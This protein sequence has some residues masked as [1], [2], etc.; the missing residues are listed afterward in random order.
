MAQLEATTSQGVA[1]IENLRGQ[2]EQ[3]QR[4]QDKLKVADS[5]LDLSHQ[6]MT[7]MRKRAFMN[8]LIRYATIGI[9]LLGTNPA[10]P[11]HSARHRIHTLS[12]DRLALLAKTVP[13]A[14]GTQL[15]ND[16]DSVRLFGWPAAPI[17]ASRDALYPL[18]F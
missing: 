11:A 15:W 9:L 13:N 2:R 1:T 18:F 8:N 12:R 4:T 5:N 6:V 10:C 17:C 7:R 3:L 16:C 14:H